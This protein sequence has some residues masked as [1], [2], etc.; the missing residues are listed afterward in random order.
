MAQVIFTAATLMLGAALTAGTVV[1][2]GFVISAALRDGRSDRE[3]RTVTVSLSL[4]MGLV[5]FAYAALSA[6]VT[7][8]VVGLIRV[9]GWTLLIDAG[10]GLLVFLLVLAIH[11]TRAAARQRAQEAEARHRMTMEAYALQL[12][13]WERRRS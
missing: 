11:R 6:T 3:R 1:L 8:S 2:S 12:D 4:L 10:L 13:A 5:V 7:S 9:A